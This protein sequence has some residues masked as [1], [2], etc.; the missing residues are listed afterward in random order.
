MHGA[1]GVKIEECHILV[2]WV[3]RFCWHVLKI[4]SLIAGVPQVVENYGKLVM[5]TSK[6]KHQVFSLEF[7]QVL[8]HVTQMAPIALFPY[9]KPFGRDSMFNR[10]FFTPAG[11]LV[12]GQAGVRQAFTAAAGDWTVHGASH[13]FREYSIFTY[14]LF[15]QE[16]YDNTLRKHVFY[17]TFTLAMIQRKNK[18]VGFAFFKVCLKSST[19]DVFE[20]VFVPNKQDTG[21]CRLWS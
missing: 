4:R 11:P 1:H 17:F 15:S 14:S 21:S 7:V 19:I 8:V 12:Y 6:T 2:F 20:G 10:L 3:G 9:A 13:M 18:H 5:F 16:R